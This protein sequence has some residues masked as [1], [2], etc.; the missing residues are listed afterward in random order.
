[1][2]P[3]VR[4]LMLGMALFPLCLLAHEL[5]HLAVLRG[6]GG[7]G[8]LLLRPWRFEFLPTSL[9]SLH[10]SGGRGL[11]PVRRV[12]FDALGPLAAALPLLI[13]SRLTRDGPLRAALVANIGILCF[14]ALIETLDYLLD[15]RLGRDLPVLGWE[16]FNYGLPLLA[17]FGAAL[18]VATRPS[19]P[20]TSAVL[21]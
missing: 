1:M 12:L 6:L 20:P 14:F 17:V 16:E 18:G 21:A 15:S 8:E 10:V 4:T 11:D 9:P 19:R 13:A 7:S 5:G 3:F 2:R